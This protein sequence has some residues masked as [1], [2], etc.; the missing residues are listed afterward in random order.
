MHTYIQCAM[1]CIHTYNA[2]CMF[3]PLARNFVHA[4]IHTLTHSYTV[5]WTESRRK[6]RQP[7]QMRNHRQ[8][9]RKC[10]LP[11]RNAPS[12]ECPCMLVSVCVCYIQASWTEM[13][14]RVTA[15][16]RVCVW[17]YVRHILAFECFLKWVSAIVS[18]GACV[19]VCARACASVCVCVCVFVCV[20][21]TMLV[22][23]QSLSMNLTPSSHYESRSIYVVVASTW[24]FYMH[25]IVGRNMYAWLMVLPGVYVCAYVCDYV[26]MCIW[27]NMDCRCI[28]E[29]TIK[30]LYISMCAQYVRV[31]WTAT[32]CFL[33]VSSRVSLCLQVDATK[34]DR[35]SERDILMQHTYICTRSLY[36]YTHV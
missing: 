6:C 36:T 26:C 27:G 14:S 5:R 11:K 21:M 34:M 16:V 33:L 20:V 35:E 13:L 8:T 9:L 1:R 23:S 10:E 18:T 30:R 15:S 29:S 4:Y 25:A 17:V 3:I 7:W 24:Y 28:C 19:C 12:S 31:Y 32:Y 2:R 22:G